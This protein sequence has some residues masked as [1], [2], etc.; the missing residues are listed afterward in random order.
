MEFVEVWFGRFELKG[1]NVL[2]AGN[3]F[4]FAV[5]FLVALKVPHI[6]FRVDFSIKI[7]KFFSC[8]SYGMDY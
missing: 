2:F 6:E 1:T 8:S 3:S 4:I 5:F 7:F